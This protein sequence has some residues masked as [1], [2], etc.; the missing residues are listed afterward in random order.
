MIL[1][2]PMISIILAIFNL[3][4]PNLIQLI[5][6]FWLYSPLSYFLPLY[7]TTSCGRVFSGKKYHAFKSSISFLVVVRPSNSLSRLLNS[8]FPD[9]HLWKVQGT[10]NASNR[11]SR[12]LVYKQLPEVILETIKKRIFSGLS[13]SV[14]VWHRN[15][16]ALI[17]W[18]H[19]LER[20]IL[21]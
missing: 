17:G 20:F 8:L 1:T 21:P 10:L 16:L 7:C 9:C 11:Y 12:M 19:I 6:W 3:Q 2:M 18:E 5:R 4:T 13:H 15:R 14:F